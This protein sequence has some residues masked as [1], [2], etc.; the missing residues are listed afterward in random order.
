M[1]RFLHILGHRRFGT[2]GSALGI[3]VST[4]LHLPSRPDLWEAF[5]LAHNVL[6]HTVRRGRELRDKKTKPRR[7]LFERNGSRMETPSQVVYGRHSTGLSL[8]TRRLLR[9][10]AQGFYL[11]RQEPETIRSMRCPAERYAPCQFLRANADC[12][13]KNSCIVRGYWF[14]SVW[15]VL[16]LN[17]MSAQWARPSRRQ[18]GA[19]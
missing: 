5:P 11:M 17:L 6:R 13:M 14:S 9:E 10:I 3:V 1:N 2:R 7:L 19:F 4:L 16:E 18:H 8:S 15:F 12:G